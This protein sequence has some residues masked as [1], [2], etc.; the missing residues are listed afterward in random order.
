MKNS[1][2][3]SAE[4]SGALTSG[5]LEMK[6]DEDLCSVIHKKLA[7]LIRDT[8]TLVP[9]TGHD[10]EIKPMTRCCER[11]AQSLRPFHYCALIRWKSCRT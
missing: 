11:T 7:M 9:M 5:N 10:T 1:T 6:G 8:W 4:S 2:I 3:Q